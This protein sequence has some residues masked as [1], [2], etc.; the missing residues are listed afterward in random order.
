MEHVFKT[1]AITKILFTVLIIVYA[2]VPL[3]TVPFGFKEIK[4]KILGVLITYVCL[5]PFFILFGVLLAKT[6]SISI[7]INPDYITYKIKNDTINLQTRETEY[8]IFD[9]IYLDNGE[10]GN[11]YYQVF[12]FGNPLQKVRFTYKL[13]S[14]DLK[15]LGEMEFLKGKFSQSI[16]FKSYGLTLLKEEC[17]Q[18]INLIK[19]YT[20][21]K[22]VFKPGFFN[23]E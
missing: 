2:V 4:W 8:F 22:P 13:E 14:E 23:E 5:S 10:V 12:E 21:L 17:K 3:V 9:Y 6:S 18:L 16:Q 7:K 20:E 19:E 15:E 1:P 11:Q